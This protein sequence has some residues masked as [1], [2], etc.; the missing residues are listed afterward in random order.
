MDFQGAETLSRQLA[1]IFVEPIDRDGSLH[2]RPVD[3]VPV[4]VSRR[5]PV[6]A[7]YADADGVLVHVLLHVIDGVLDELEVYREDSGPVVIPPA[8]ASALEVEPWVE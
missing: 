6:E 3:P 5:I 8:D 1:S 4:T 2:L 7:A